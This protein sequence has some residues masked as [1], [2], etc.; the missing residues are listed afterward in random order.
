[1]EPPLATPGQVVDVWSAWPD[2]ETKS[3]ILRTTHM[4]V[5]R[6]HVNADKRVPTYEAQGEITFFCVQGRV[7]VE[8]CGN[9]RELNS[10][11]ML[12]LLVNEPFSLLGLEETSLLITILRPQ[13]EPST[14]FIGEGTPA[15]KQ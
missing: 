5:M 7:L 1:M 2:G 10:G 4:E 12:Y 13:A 11:Q 6:L 3:A 9:V 14:P 8:A 15:G